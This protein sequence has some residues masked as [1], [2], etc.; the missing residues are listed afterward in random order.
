M[1]DLVRLYAKEQAG[2]TPCRR[3]DAAL[4]RLLDFYRHTCAIGN[5]VLDPHWDRVAM[6]EPGPHCHPVR[7]ADTAA[8]IAWFTAEDQNIQAAQRLAVG[9][10]WHRDVWHLTWHT[11]VF[12][13]QR[14]LIWER[15]QAAQD[16]LAAAVALDDAR[17]MHLA[18][19]CV[20]SAESHVGRVE[21]AVDHLNQALRIAIESDDLVG[22][23]YCMHTLQ[24]AVARTADDSPLGLEYAEESLRL[25]RMLE[26]PVWVARKLNAVGYDAVLLGRLRAGTGRLHGSPGH[27]QD[28][29]RPRERS[30]HTGQSR[31]IAA[32]WATSDT[33]VTAILRSRWR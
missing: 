29:R 8:T 21:Q 9:R 27:H 12:R 30:G 7:L 20:G 4:H 16:G 11:M 17:T 19:R 6:D 26:R 24:M 13:R 23:A 31:P 14:G 15:L 3:A 22:R 2:C 5:L 25:F 28:T 18:L 32:A 1:H 10:G 33:A